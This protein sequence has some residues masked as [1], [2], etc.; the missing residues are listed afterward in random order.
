MGDVQVQVQIPQEI[1][2]YWRWFPAFGIGVPIL[3]IA[4]VVRSVAA[5]VV[6]MLFFGMVRHCLGALRAL[7][8]I[9]PDD[10]SCGVDVVAGSICLGV[11]LVVL[12]FKLRTRL[13]NLSPA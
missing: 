7:L 11:C 5:T 12:A 4:A 6:S 13:E 9:A 3:G 8:I 1:V 2:Q 10:R